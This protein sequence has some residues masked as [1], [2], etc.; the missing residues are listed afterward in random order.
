[1]HKCRHCG[2]EVTIRGSQCRICKDGL[3]RYGMN[4]LDQIK[5]L[6][7]QNGSCYLCDDPVQLFDGHKGGMIDHCHST[8]NVRGVLCNKCNTIVGRIENH[9][10]PKRILEYVKLT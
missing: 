2:E 6:E 1:M 3:Y 7:S 9:K 5:L 8:G 4:R 10:N